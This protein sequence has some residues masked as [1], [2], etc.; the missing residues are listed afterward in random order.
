ML[1]KFKPI[2]AI[3]YHSVNIFVIASSFSFV[4]VSEVG[5]SHVPD[6]IASALSCLATTKGKCHSEQKAKNL[7]DSAV[8]EFALSEAEVL[9]SE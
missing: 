1:V 3:F 6:E 4:I 2:L 5:Q 8:V 9:S 7:R